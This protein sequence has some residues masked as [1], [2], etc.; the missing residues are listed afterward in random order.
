MREKSVRIAGVVHFLVRVLKEVSN[1]I[2][3]KYNTD[4]IGS[5][6][7]RGTFINLLNTKSSLQVADGGMASDMEGSCE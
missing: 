2:P 1:P 7:L 3:P 4:I 5:N 6:S